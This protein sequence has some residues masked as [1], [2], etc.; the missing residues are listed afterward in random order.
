MRG[1]PERNGG[2]PSHKYDSSEASR[3]VAASDPGCPAQPFPGRGQE[4]A[5]RNEINVLNLFDSEIIILYREF[6]G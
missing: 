3:S 5:T 4:W 6:I 2:Y 1:C